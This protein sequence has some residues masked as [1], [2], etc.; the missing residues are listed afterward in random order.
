MFIR[1]TICFKQTFGVDTV[2]KKKT[3]NLEYFDA[4]LWDLFC[5]YR[6]TFFKISNII[7]TE[8]RENM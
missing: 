6:T 2:V 3:M 1:T 5:V 8:L 4:F 7:F